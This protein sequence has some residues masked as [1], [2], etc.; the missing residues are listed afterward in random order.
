MSECYDCYWYDD[1]DVPV[2]VGCGYCMRFPPTAIKK[3]EQP[4]AMGHYP[5][6]SDCGKI[7][8]EFKQKSK[9]LERVKR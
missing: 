1:S 9:F 4:Y 2:T 6:V 5:M 3:C 8:G 7:C